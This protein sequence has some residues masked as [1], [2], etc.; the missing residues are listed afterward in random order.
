MSYKIKIFDEQ[1]HSTLI[2]ERKISAIEEENKL[3]LTTI[4]PGLFY[5]VS[6][7]LRDIR[8]E[9]FLYVP[10]TT[11]NCCHDPKLFYSLIYRDFSVMA[12]D[13][14][15]E[16]KI[17]SPLIVDGLPVG[18]FLSRKGKADRALQQ[19][20]FD[21]FAQS[22]LF[23]MIYDINDKI[24]GSEAIAQ[25]IMNLIAQ[26]FSQDSFLRR[27]PQWIVE[28]LAGGMAAL[29]YRSG[30]DYLL[31][32]IAGQ[33]SYY[34]ETPSILTE[35]QKSVYL[36]AGA[37]ENY[38]IPSGALP[39]F[40]SEIKI[41]P[42]IRFILTGKTKQGIEYILT[43]ISSN[44]TSYSHALFFDRL[45]HI[46]QGI[47]ER[48][49]SGQPDWSNI[50]K[51]LDKQDIA[52]NS[53]Q[54]ILES[55]FSLLAENININRLS[56]LRC[57]PLE[58]RLEI[59]ASA[60]K[61]GKSQIMPGIQLSMNDPD[62]LNIRE[63][64]K[65]KF[66]AN[67]ARDIA[68]RVEYQ[69]Y[70][71]GARSSILIPINGENDIIGLMAVYS[72]MT[73]DY[74][75][76][77]ISIFETLARYIGKIISTRDNT[78]L[79]EIYSRQLGEMYS[80]LTALENLKT[81]GEL[82]SGVFH[83][84]NN[85]I[86]AILGRSQLI[87]NRLEKEPASKINDKTIADLKTIE[88]AAFDSA[89]ILGRLRQLSQS[90]R[91]EKRAAI[92]LNEILNDS[93]EMIRPKWEKICKEKNIRLLLRK[94]LSGQISIQADPS[95]LREV[96]TNLLLNSLDAMP[97]GGEIS[98]T[99][100]VQDKVVQITVSDTGQGIPADI[101]GN[102]FEPFFTTKGEQGTGL[103]LPLSK[104]IIN[105]HNGEIRV[106]SVPGKR[107]TFTVDLP[108]QMSAGVQKNE[109]ISREFDEKKQ[110]ILA[111]TG[112]NDLIQILQEIVSSNNNF[113]LSNVISGREAVSFCGRETYD[114]M[115]IDAKLQDIDGMSLISQVRNIDRKIRIIF[116]TA[117]E[118][119]QSVSNIMS[120]GID[121]LFVRPFDTATIKSVLSN[122]L[123]VPPV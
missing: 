62:I 47:S 111:V 59:E 109:K 114:V 71:E 72:P 11:M 107:T 93:L 37:G 101:I 21:E 87:M 42:Q 79:M 25:H 74:L 56:L 35:E 70:K 121:S 118:I 60:N 1:Q 52:D 69:L 30:D 84:L 61:S 28:F 41:P 15:F 53:R 38:F 17:F 65:S 46:L 34:E 9:K 76:K 122:L 113:V 49:F 54:K 14:K 103:G 12:A 8:E 16:D 18:G 102:I 58:N 29:Y 20:L 81:L 63:T 39:T 110:R 91:T 24:A 75:A 3:Y 57:S 48:N 2:A 31:Q 6:D 112:E 82:A 64:G 27:L 106:T 10:S 51:I 5:S 36:E 88:K 94:D 33:F 19:R 4:L 40:V 67:L 104:K 123:E 85:I 96:F 105:D 73:G 32:K 68:N 97:E 86:G 119:D 108:L 115:V 7:K 95:E 55:V 80:K 43:G 99:S 92:D 116:S 98:I 100:R 22:A 117:S 90:K 13:I 45:R 77:Y 120:L 78:H 66:K 50:F 89:A 26:S 44:I 23:K 83:D